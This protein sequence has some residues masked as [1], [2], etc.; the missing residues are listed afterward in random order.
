MKRKLLLFATILLLSTI[1]AFAQTGNTGPLTWKLNQNTGIL[2]I[3]GEGDMPDYIWAPWFDY[4]DSIKTVIIENGVTRIGGGAFYFHKNLKTVIIPNSVKSIRGN[5]FFV[6]ETLSSLIIP[7]S[8]IEI[9]KSAFM[10]SGL[11]SIN[12]PNSVINIG[13]TAFSSCLNLVSI[14]VDNDN[15]NYSSLEGVLFNKNK[16]T[17]ICCPGG[18][19]GKYVIPNG[20]VTIFESAF[21]ECN[22]ITEIEIPNSVSS[23]MSRAFENCFS[24]ASITLPSGINSIERRTFS[25]CYSLSSINIPNTVKSIGG[26]AFS[27]CL[28]L[29]S[30][31][32]PSS[33][34]SIG[35]EAFSAC[36]SLTS[37]TNLNPNPVKIDFITFVYVNI[38]EIVL[39]VPSSSVSLYKNTDVWKDFIIEGIEVGINEPIQ[40]VSNLKIYPNPTTGKICIS[41]DDIESDLNLWD[42]TFFDMNGRKLCKNNDFVLEITNHITIDISHFPNGIYF[43]QIKNNIVKILKQ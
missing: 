19:T 3:S 17:L 31:V 14:N 42:I 22:K 18:K 11:T 34:T 6:C 4:R 33:V 35:S 40:D 9:G 24:L 32:I 12:I 25:S 29:N 38:S 37:I 30:I 27:K 8:V 5:A 20:V 26:S 10:F 7:N 1:Y 21:L 16:T 36:E 2:T 28:S 13:K 23:I 43:L 41:F 39:K 15:P